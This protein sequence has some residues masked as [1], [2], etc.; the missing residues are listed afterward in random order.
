M[1][2]D[3]DMTFY[4]TANWGCEL[5]GTGATRATCA[6]V[7]AKYFGVTYTH[8]SRTNYDKYYIATP[9]NGTWVV[10]RD[11]SV[12]PLKKE[13]GRIVSAADEYR[14][15]IVTP[16]MHG[17]PDIEVFQE[18]IRCLRKQAGFFPCSTAG[19]HVHIEIKGMRPTAIINI[20]NELH[21]KQKLLMKA[22]N[23]ST[24]SPRYSYCKMIPTEL[25]QNLKRVR[26][27][28]G[29]NLT[30]N[31]IADVYYPIMG[32]GNSERHSRYPQARYYICNVTRGLVTD[33]LYYLGTIEFRLFNAE[34][35]AGK[36]KSYIQFCLLLCQ[37][38]SQISKSS[39]KETLVDS[40]ESEKY[41]FRCFLLKLNC[42]GDEFKTMRKF[43]LQEF[44]E[45]S[46]AWR[47]TG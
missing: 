45:Q 13:N 38:C 25:V 11:S 17:A 40:I 39:Y 47:C 19:F 32:N 3:V 1:Q 37:Y 34:N 7:I 14:V 35:H 29:P 12:T 46:S 8:P 20:F 2:R 26:R 44:G 22:L 18:V 24:T 15:E 16:V 43:F 6:K 10:M 42:I 4:N 23:L 30:L 28:K 33:S 41:K 36:L 21:S 31:D 5:E 9:S 27:K